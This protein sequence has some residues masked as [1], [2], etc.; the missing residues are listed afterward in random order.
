MDTLEQDRKLIAD[1]GGPSAVARKL[2]Y[3]KG[4]AQRVQNWLTRGIPP[5]VK[6]AYPE[7]FMYGR[8]APTP[9]DAAPQ[10]ASC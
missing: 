6:V 8:M 4:G 2:Q 7:L 9:A 10:G 3:A 5:A 1:L